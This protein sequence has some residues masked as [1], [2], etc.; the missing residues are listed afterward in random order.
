MK[1]HENKGSLF[2]HITAIIGLALCL[3]LQGKAMFFTIYRFI[4]AMSVPFGNLRWVLS[5]VGYKTGL[6][7]RFSSISML[8]TFILCRIV[9]IPWHWY[10][11]FLTL[12][13]E[14]CALILSISLWTWLILNSVLID[15]INV[16]W[17]LKMAKG[18][19][20]LYGNKAKES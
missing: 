17:V 5:Y 7:Y 9:T 2:H 6:L 18:A 12:Y 13:T 10:E 11:M 14:K 20:K 16:Y 15:V 19:Y 8:I 1:L 4:S 3:F